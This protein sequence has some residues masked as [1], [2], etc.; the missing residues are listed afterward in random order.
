VRFE[1]DVV[2]GPNRRAATVRRKERPDEVI[3]ETIVDLGDRIGVRVT[4]HALR[5]AFAVSF[6]TSRPGALESL[7]ALMSHSRIDT[8]GVYSR[9]LIR[10]LAMEAG[11][12]IEDRRPIRDSN[13]CRRRERAVS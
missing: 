6:L 9:A 5:R 10:D 1:L 4:V 7:Q 11:V 12:S 3:W 13:P 8:T 2:T